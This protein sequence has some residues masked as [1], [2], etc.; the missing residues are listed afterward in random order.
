MKSI[1]TNALYT[2]SVSTKNIML[3]H[4]RLRHLGSIMIRWIIE[5]SHGHLLKD[6]KI[7]LSSENSCTACS[8]GKLITKPSPSK[9]II[10][11][12]SFLERIQRDIYGPIYPSYRPFRYFMVLIDASNKWSHV[13]LLSTRNVA[14][15][16]LITQ[17]IIL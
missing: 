7:L 5:N 17:I 12:P 9:V 11:S 3:W 6:L 16:R 14:F 2:R 10:E 4:D 8:Q 13:C 1:E 15:T